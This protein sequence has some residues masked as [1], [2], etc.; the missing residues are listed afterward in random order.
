MN[1]CS[2]EFNKSKT[3]SDS[4]CYKY[5]S[6]SVLGKDN[7]FIGTRD[8]NGKVIREKVSEAEF[9]NVECRLVDCR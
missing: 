3:I 8:E 7:Y 9:K 1:I 6:K 5:S 4:D 2:K